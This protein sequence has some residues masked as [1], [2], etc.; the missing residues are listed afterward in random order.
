MKILK[1]FII[2]AAIICFTSCS[3]DSISFGTVEYYPSFWWVDANVTPVTK[4]FDFDFSEDA[5]NDKNSFAE[6]Q[7]VDNKGNPIST[8]EMQVYMDGQQLA[9]NKF[10]ISSEVTSKELTFTFSPDVKEGKHQGYLK[11]VNHSLDRLDAQPLSPGQKVDAFQW[12]L[13]FEKGMNP[14]ARCLLWLTIIFVALAILWFLLLKSFFFPQIRLNR[15]EITSDK[16]YF[17]NVKINGAHKVIMT[18]K[19]ISQCWLSKLF[20]G[21]IIVI[22]DDV[23]RD[24]WSITPKKRKKTARINLRGKYIINPVTSEIQNFSE[25]KIQNINTKELLTIKIL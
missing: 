18:D 12:T 7:F 14:L 24:E 1:L 20:L 9:N 3:D 8:S 16:G 17:Q 21:E 6:F 25:Y 10:K 19:P 4:T 2:L 13:R 23:W 11:L 5:K 22:Q 15:L